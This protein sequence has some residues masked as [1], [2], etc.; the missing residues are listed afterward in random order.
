MFGLPVGGAL[1]SELNAKLRKDNQYPTQLL[2]VPLLAENDQFPFEDVRIQLIDSS[3]K[4]Y[5]IQGEY[6]F[7][8]GD[9]CLAEVQRLVRYFDLRYK[10]QKVIS[11]STIDGVEL[12]H[13]DGYLSKSG[14][15]K[16][17]VYCASENPED[18]A[19]KLFV[20]IW[21]KEL[22]TEAEALWDEV[23]KTL[24]N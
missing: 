12:V 15:R 24:K 4:I 1:P 3:K 11:N 10:G 22:A 21:D 9:E 19:K 13:F 8:D 17:E 7:N 23:H 5:S 14:H 20:S 6:N 16:L 18:R 2:Y